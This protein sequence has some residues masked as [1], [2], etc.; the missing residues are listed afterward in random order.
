MFN[1]VT[2]LIPIVKG[3]IPKQNTGTH[4]TDIMSFCTLALRHLHFTH[5]LCTDTGCAVYIVPPAFNHSC[6]ACSD[7]MSG[8]ALFKEYARHADNH[9]RSAHVNHEDSDEEAGG[10][11]GAQNDP[12]D[13][14]GFNSYGASKIAAWKA[15]NHSQKWYTP[16]PKLRPQ[17]EVEEEDGKYKAGGFLTANDFDEPVCCPHELRHHE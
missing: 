14:G 17:D 4:P 16:K 9:G 1:Y 6:I 5:S 11:Q 7:L 10:T 8:A 15:R 12:N 2:C 3:Q 13:G